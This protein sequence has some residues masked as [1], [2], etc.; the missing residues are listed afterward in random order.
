VLFLMNSY[1][2]MVGK[3]VLKLVLLHLRGE[4]DSFRYIVWCCDNV[5]SCN[6]YN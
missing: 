1:C 5:K 2:F 4:L 3:F 6:K